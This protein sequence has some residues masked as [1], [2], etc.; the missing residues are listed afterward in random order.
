[1]MTSCILNRLI[2]TAAV[3]FLVAT[4]AYAITI[5]TVPVGNPGN[6]GELSGAGA[7]AGGHGPDA[8]V[9]AVDYEYNIGT[10][11]VTCAQY[12]E[13]LNTVAVS[14]AYALYNGFMWMSNSGC[15]IQRTGS[16]GSFAYSV[17]PDRANRPVNYV[18]WYDAARFCNWL[19][20]GDTERGVYTFSGRYEVTD[21]LDHETA[22]ETLG[23][24]AWFL[25]TEDEWYKAAY[26][27]NDGITGNY[28][29]Y[30]TGTNAVPSNDLI[31]PDPGNNANFRYTTTYYTTEV[32]EFEN[33]E[34][35]Y[36]T[37]DQGGN[38]WEWTETFPASTRG[39]R[40]GSWGSYPNYLHASFRGINDNPSIGGNGAG[41]R[42][43]SIPEPGSITL[44]L[45][46]LSAGLLCRR[47][48][49]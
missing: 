26:H 46:G 25:P 48:R 13:F 42:V 16:P 22:A 39:L 19:T 43:A 12:V 32:G 21:I 17:A 33:S 24:T 9:G 7:G 4:G 5:D 11:E 30:P 15:K 14:D 35:P 36:G 29:D 6:A 28:W 45:C 27:K 40:G 49:P 37:F 23:S 1:M 47:R 41:F 8:I 18:S 10:Y 38:L 34:S 44:L 31:D 2:V 20:T 3:A